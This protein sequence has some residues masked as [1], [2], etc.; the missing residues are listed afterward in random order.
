MYIDLYIY[1]I[2]T[3]SVVPFVKTSVVSVVTSCSG[4]LSDYHKHF[5]RKG[6]YP[7]YWTFFCPVTAIWI[8]YS[9]LIYFTF[10]CLIGIVTTS[11]TTTTMIMIFTVVNLTCVK[12][13]AML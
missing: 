6:L 10:G 2:P 12:V 1:I 5:I 11:T 9:I 7:V 13:D 8:I 4:F 3:F